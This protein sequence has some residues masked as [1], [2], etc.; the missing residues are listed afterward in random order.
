ML[1]KQGVATF[2]AIKLKELSCVI[3]VGGLGFLSWVYISGMCVYVRSALSLSASLTNIW[4]KNTITNRSECA[5]QQALC[6]IL[7]AHPCTQTSIWLCYYLR[8]WIRGRIKMPPIVCFIQTGKAEWRRN[9]PALNRL[10]KRD[11]WFNE[12]AL[13]SALSSSVVKPKFHHIL[14]THACCHL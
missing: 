5:T 13:W 2:A 6:P 9:G 10:C 11:W 3:C 12:R 8:W 4:T 14:L 1:C 7:P